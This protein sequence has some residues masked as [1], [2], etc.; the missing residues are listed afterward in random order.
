MGL[1]SVALKDK[2]EFDIGTEMSVKFLA[3]D[4]IESFEIS[5]GY[6]V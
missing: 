1:I 4:L 6:M 3:D 5:F 2:G